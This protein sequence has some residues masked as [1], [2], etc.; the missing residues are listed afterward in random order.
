MDIA[1]LC[2]L[3]H[4]LSRH[5]LSRG[6]YHNVPHPN[7]VCLMSELAKKISRRAL[8]GHLGDLGVIPIH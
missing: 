2:C 4:A 1:F 5:Y 8:L 7:D 3:E 6:S